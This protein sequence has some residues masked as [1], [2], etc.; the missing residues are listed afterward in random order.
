MTEVRD[1]GGRFADS[2]SIVEDSRRQCKTVETS[3]TQWKILAD[4][5][6]YCVR[7]GIVSSQAFVVPAT[8]CQLYS[9]TEVRDDGGRFADTLSNVEDS[10]RQCNTVETSGTQWKIFCRQFILLRTK[11]HSFQPG[12][13]C[14]SDT[15]PSHEVRG[16]FEWV[17]CG[18]TMMVAN[19]LTLYG[20]NPH[21]GKQCKTVEGIGRQWKTV[22]DS[23]RQW[24]TVED[25][26]RQ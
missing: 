5:L 9:V 22:E 8:R 2:L 15:V 10:R 25:S 1:C 13:C 12:F 6:F 7:S 16:H 18:F 19:L 3:G 4:S 11:W 14:A 21:S 26:G 24:K 20:A 23:R 17:S